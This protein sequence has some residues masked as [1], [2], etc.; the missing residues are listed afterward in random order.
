MNILVK[1]GLAV[2]L[3]LAPFAAQGQTERIIG[4][5]TSITL[6]A[7]FQ[8]QLSASGIAITDLA[9]NAL[10]NG[11]N[12]LPDVQGVI[13]LQSA[14]THVFFKGG[15]QVVFQGTTVRLEDFLLNVTGP[16]AIYSATFIE[17]G[18]VLGRREIFFVNQNPNLVLPLQ[19]QTSMIKL[20]ELS[21][22]LAPAFIREINRLTGQQTL[23]A[24]TQVATS[25]S[26]PI[27]VPDTPAAVQ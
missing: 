19:V 23:N 2:T 8:Q 5:Y 16:S 15:Y 6:N 20:P 27:V 17:N 12:V 10:Q 18:Q 9:Q 25:N 26:F 21:L 4:G 13:N 24:G 14:N 1:T 11:T 3:L 22:G 7:T